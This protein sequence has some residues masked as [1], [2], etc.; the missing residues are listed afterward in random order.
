MRKDEMNMMIGYALSR[1]CL[2]MNTDWDAKKKTKINIYM[3]IKIIN[4]LGGK[5]LE[6]YARFAISEAVITLKKENRE[7]N[8]ETLTR[9]RRLVWMV[10]YPYLPA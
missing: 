2:D 4:A 5:K 7:V 6:G 10:F 9:F 1:A 3:W 8:E